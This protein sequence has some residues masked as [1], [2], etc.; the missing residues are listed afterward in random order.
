MSLRSSIQSNGSPVSEVY[1]NRRSHAQESRS[2]DDISSDSTGMEDRKPAFKTRRTTRSR[3]SVCRDDS[4]ADQQLSGQE[5]EFGEPLEVESS[6][7]ED[8]TISTR[9]SRV[10]PAGRNGKQNESPNRKSTRKRERSDSES[11]FR[12]AHNRSAEA[13]SSYLDPSS[14]EFGTDVSDAEDLSPPTPTQYK[15]TRRPKKKPKVKK[16]K[17]TFRSMESDFV[18]R[19]RT[20][21]SC[22]CEINE[23]IIEKEKGVRG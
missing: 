9:A 5:S 1:G 23:Q 11:S 19:N 16:R 20:N 15:A 3:R 4:S 14:S 21:S 13:P 10:R 17:G 7:P 6:D 18:L 8:I 2:A 12:A 22:S